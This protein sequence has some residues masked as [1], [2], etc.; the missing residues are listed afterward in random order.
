MKSCEINQ[1]PLFR[2]AA[3]FAA[4]LAVSAAVAQQYAITDLGTLSGPVS[5]AY[6][7]NSFGHV[8]GSSVRSD[9]DV[10]GFV[11]SGSLIGVPPLSG[12]RQSHVFDLN[13]AGQVV[14]TS[15]DLGES[16]VHGFL[17]QNQVAVPLG[18]FAPHGVNAS[19]DVTGYVTI[20]DAS[21]GW[22][23]HAAR[24][25]SGAITDLGTLGGHFSYAYAIANDGR[26]VGA[27]ALSNE[28][29]QHAAMWIGGAPHD[30]GTLG[31][32]ASQAYAMNQAGDVVGWANT[33]GGAPHAFLFQTDE[34]GAVTL[35]RDLGDLGGGYS[36]AYAV[37]SHQQ[38]VG[39][40]S[41]KAFMWQ[42]GTMLNL[43]TALP[44]SSG[45]ILDAA[46]DINDAG[47]IV[48][49]GRYQG[50]PHAF[51]LSP[52]TCPDFDANGVVD[53]S[54]LGVLLAHFGVT[55][56]ATFADGDVDGDGAV[57]ESD[58]GVL[59][60]QWQAHC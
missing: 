41:A 25:R 43:N 28:Y 32:T 23:E 13:D 54:D 5:G 51:L 27:A 47:Q 48:G 40:S 50:Y 9:A 30:L 45:W 57:N 53:E 49:V 6:C 18:D 55:S 44:P 1:T 24:W 10:N 38:V 11:W 21:Y 2:G 19:G 3:A 22:V 8:G 15:Y 17:L 34:S 20:N 42:S 37:N 46:W 56:G 7:I 60:S 26:I 29:T 4:A 36:Y 31:G 58:L 39:T 16:H 12:D 33:A 14:A 52:R 35:R 59:L